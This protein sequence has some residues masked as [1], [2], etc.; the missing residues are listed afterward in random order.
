MV[1]IGVSAL[2][3]AGVTGC[4]GSGTSARGGGGSATTPRSVDGA[5][6][7][8]AAYAKTLQAK[9]AEIYFRETV[10]ASSGTSQSITGTGAVDFAHHAFLMTMNL[11][12]TGSMVVVIVGT[13]EYV[14]IPPAA[15]ERMPGHTPWVSID[16]N[17]LVQAKLGGSLAQWSAGASNDPSQVLA[18]LSA[19]SDRVT[20]IGHPTVDGVITTEYRAQVDVAKA[21]ARTRRKSGYAA[22]QLLARTLKPLGSRTLPMELWIGVDH[23]VRRFQ[24]TIVVPTGGNAPGGALRTTVLM[25][26]DRYGTPVNIAAPPRNQVTDLTTRILHPGGV[27][28]S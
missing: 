12:T 20:I 1:A 27:S 19:V 26:F 8:R 7:V 3:A 21:L 15:R 4:G 23:L 10:Q 17:R 22:A 16:L 28:S 2:L 9:T 5:R 25:D 18:Q 14:E 24:E 6:V 13:T 11:P